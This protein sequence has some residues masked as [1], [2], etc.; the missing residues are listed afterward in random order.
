MMMRFR[1]TQCNSY[2][3]VR[4]VLDLTEPVNR[5]QQQYSVTVHAYL[6]DSTF[7]ITLEDATQLHTWLII[8]ANRD[9]C[10]AA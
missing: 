8:R 3:I 7:L 5:P 6:T 1:A 4:P 9:D 2:G 10:P